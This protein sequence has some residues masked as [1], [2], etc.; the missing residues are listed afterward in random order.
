MCACHT[1]CK[2]FV[3][4]FLCVFSSLISSFF[5]HWKQFLIKVS[6]GLDCELIF[7][8][9][10]TPH[11]SFCG[12]FQVSNEFD[13]LWESWWKK[14]E[15]R[16]KLCRFTLYGTLLLLL[17]NFPPP[18]VIWECETFTA[19]VVH[20]FQLKASTHFMQKDERALEWLVS[21]H[22]FPPRYPNDDDAELSTE[23]NMQKKKTGTHRLS[24]EMARNFHAHSLSPGDAHLA[25]HGYELK[26]VWI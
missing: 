25:K 8:L 1:F 5:A 11:P 18:H 23:V 7:S 2:K 12:F 6:I 26:V 22:L 21:F 24:A 20:N 15:V 17:H 10:H 14:G 16:T 19:F 4:A 9:A 13:T 3:Q